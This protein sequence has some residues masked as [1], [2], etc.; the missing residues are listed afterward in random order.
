MGWYWINFFRKNN[1]SAF[2]GVFFICVIHP[3]L[4]LLLGSGG[5][6]CAGLIWLV[7][8]TAWIAFFAP[9][10]HHFWAAA[11]TSLLPIWRWDPPITPSSPPSLSRGYN[12]GLGGSDSVGKIRK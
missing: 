1:K 7:A 9:A 11:P 2:V 5:L 8:F 10:Q 6:L 12:R 4:S 3:G